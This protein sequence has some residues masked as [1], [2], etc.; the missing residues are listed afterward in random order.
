[1]T[2]EIKEDSTDNKYTEEEENQVEE[3]TVSETNQGMTSTIEE[4]RLEQVEHEVLV[5]EPKKTPTTTS[6]EKQSKQVNH[7]VTASEDERT[8]TTHIEE[9]HSDPE[10]TEQFIAKK[11]D[12]S[13][14]TTRLPNQGRE[15]CIYILSVITCESSL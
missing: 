9:T 10:R 14:L 13:T 5:S 3:V 11:D 4:K 1:M 2:E 6:D 8:K 7:E 15:S 12:V